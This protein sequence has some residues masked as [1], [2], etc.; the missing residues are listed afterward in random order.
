MDRPQDMEGTMGGTL[1]STLAQAS[2]SSGNNLSDST[3]ASRGSKTTTNTP[4]SKSSCSPFLGESLVVPPDAQILRP[5][6]LEH[7]N[8]VIEELKDEFDRHALVARTPRPSQYIWVPKIPQDLFAQIETDLELFPGVRVTVAHAESS[9]LL[10]VMPGRQYERIISNFHSIV[11]SYLNSMGL[12]LQNGDFTGQ[13][14]ERIPG[15]VSSKEPD[16]AFGPYDARVDSAADE[17]PSLVLDVG[18]SESLDE[19]RQDARWC[20]SV[21]ESAPLPLQHRRDCYDYGRLSM[22]S[23]HITL[24]LVVTSPPSSFHLEA[25]TISILYT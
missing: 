5:R 23:R 4:P 18:A 11:L 22:P 2:L 24:S 19:L 10:K 16:W 7:I 8:D 14:A 17:Y 15:V 12:S 21:P 1:T 3:S 9:V 13:G 25:F 6:S 20:L